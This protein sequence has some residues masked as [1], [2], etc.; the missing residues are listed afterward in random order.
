VHP[1]DNLKVTSIAIYSNVPITLPNVARVWFTTMS[2]FIKTEGFI[3]VG[4]EESMWQVTQNGHSSVLAAYT[5][6]FVM[7]CAHNSPNLDS[8]RVRVLEVFDVTYEGNL[9]V[10]YEGDLLALPPGVCL[11]DKRVYHYSTNKY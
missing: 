8:S 9:H 1:L 5:D 10:T 6:D 7:T 11:F 2:E 3:K 4:Y